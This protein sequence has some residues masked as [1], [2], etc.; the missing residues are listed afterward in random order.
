MYNILVSL[1][2]DLRQLSEKNTGYILDAFSEIYRL[3]SEINSLKKELGLW[4]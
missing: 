3:F 1:N 4:K 2:N